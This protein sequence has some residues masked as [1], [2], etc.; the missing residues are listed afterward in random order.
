MK[1]YN[2]KQI[3]E[4][5]DTTEET[6]RRWIRDGKLAATQNS[7]KEGNVISELDL[8]K[9]AEVAP[10]YAARIIPFI[11]LAPSVGVPLAL[12]GGIAVAAMSRK[13]GDTNEV[14]TSELNRLIERHILLSEEIIAQKKKEIELAEK[15]ILG[16][17]EKI[18]E[19]RKMMEIEE[20]E[21]CSQVI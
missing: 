21:K 7:K 6:V 13:R 8:E 2:V 14:D 19:L 9:F 18:K 3:A 5:L 20:D 1:T 4:M 11:G 15:A 12:A 17:E 16:E 10:K